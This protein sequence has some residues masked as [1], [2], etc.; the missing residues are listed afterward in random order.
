MYY[1]VIQDLV[2]EDI[3]PEDLNEHR[4]YMM[5][6]ISNNFLLISGPF[7]GDKKGGMFVIQVESEKH[8]RKIIENDPGVVSGI[9][10]NEYRPYNL[11]FI[12]TN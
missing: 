2:K 7:T 11:S 4:T 12:K 10:K 5:E 1:M 3:Q 6:L 9:L 8:L